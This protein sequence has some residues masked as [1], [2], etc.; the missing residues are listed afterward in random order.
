MKNKNFF[1]IKK[2]NLEYNVNKHPKICSY[3]F[4]LDYYTLYQINESLRK[5]FNFFSN[6]V[7]IDLLDVMNIEFDINLHSIRL[8]KYDNCTD[9][10]TD[11]KLVGV[12]NIVSSLEVGIVGFSDKV[13]SSIINVLFGGKSSSQYFKNKNVYK[14]TKCEKNI[15]KKILNIIKKV[16]SLSWK[17]EFNVDVEF[18]NVRLKKRNSLKSIISAGN[19]FLFTVFQIQCGN[20]LGFLNIIFP[21]SW[22]KTFKNKLINHSDKNTFIEKKN[23]VKMSLKM[24]YNIKIS[25]DIRLV[26]VSVLLSD[27]FSLKVGDIIS[28]KTPENAFAYS[29]DI[30]ILIGKY[31]MHNKNYVFF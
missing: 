31:K 24:I 12:Y 30:P 7:C 27:I 18:F 15:I 6:K 8:E 10:F 20:T 2:N 16:Y 28:I 1:Q 14:L 22:I 5:I 9:Y 19:I 3:D 11:S 4:E 21:F 26:S 23:I 25:L 13:I 17:N 29:H